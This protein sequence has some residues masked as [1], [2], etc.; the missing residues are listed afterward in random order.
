MNKN[1]EALLS[2]AFGL[3]GI[4]LWLIPMIGIIICLVGLFLGT[5]A[6]NTSKNM[7]VSGM[8][9]NSIGLILTILRVGL[10]AYF[11]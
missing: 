6:Y 11:T 8:I 5:K 2:I 4:V 9:I 3:I 10:V 7:A 1:L